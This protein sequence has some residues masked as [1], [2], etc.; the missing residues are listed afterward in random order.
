MTLHGISLGRIELLL[1]VPNS[2]VEV[3]NKVKGT[4]LH[5]KIV[6]LKRTL[7]AMGDV[8]LRTSSLRCS[9]PCRRT[10]RNLSV[11]RVALQSVNLNVSSMHFSNGTVT[12]SLS[13]HR[14]HVG[15]G[16]KLRIRSL[17]KQ[18][19]VSSVSVRIPALRLRAPR[20]DIDLRTGVSFSTLSRAPRNRLSTRVSKRVNGRS[21]LLFAN[22]LPGSFIGTCPGTPVILHLSTSKGVGRLHLGATRTR[23]RPTFSFGTSKVVQ[24]LA[25]STLLTTSL[26]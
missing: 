15:R 4:G 16:G 14:A 13:V 19:G 11:G 10:A 18:F 21:V 3:G 8:G 17:A 26:S 12:L 9:L 24:R 5:R 6:S 25:S 22:R 7:C 1:D 23:L 2:D 20:S